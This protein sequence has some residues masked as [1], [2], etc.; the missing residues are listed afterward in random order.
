MHFHEHSRLG[1]IRSALRHPIFF[2][3]ITLRSIIAQP[4]SFR[5]ERGNES[6]LSFSLPLS[7]PLPP[8]DSFTRRSSTADFV[9]SRF[10]LPPPFRFLSTIA[11]LEEDGCC[12]VDTTPTVDE[13]TDRVF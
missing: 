4:L 9:D 12:Y 1:G 13:S 10:P 2:L 8:L 5:N 6:Y 3:L 11:V 7:P